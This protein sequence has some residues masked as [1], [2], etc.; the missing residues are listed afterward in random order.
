VTFAIEHLVVARTVALIRRHQNDLSSGSWA[1]RLPRTGSNGHEL[2]VP[3]RTVEHR[4]AQ[5][6]EHAVSAW[7][8]GRRLSPG[9]TR[10]ANAAVKERHHRDQRVRRRGQG[11]TLSCRPWSRAA[12]D[13]R[14]LCHTGRP[15]RTLPHRRSSGAPKAGP[16]PYRHAGHRHRT[17]NR[18]QFHGSG[19]SISLVRYPTRVRVR[20]GAP[21][22][23]PI[24]NQIVAERGPRFRRLTLREPMTALG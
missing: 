22:A 1:S 2:P 17:S 7:T 6:V 4:R 16:A 14:A 9:T 19:S 24:A 3:N 10:P 8:I 5:V 11:S 18:H 21:L 13:E 15:R 12:A 20:H 23:E